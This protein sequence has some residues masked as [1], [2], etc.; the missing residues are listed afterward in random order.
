MRSVNIGLIGLGGM[1]KIHFQNSM[2]LKNAKVLAVAD[3]SKESRS[4]ARERGIKQVYDNYEKLLEDPAID[5]VIISLPNHFHAECA[6]KA[7]EHEKHIFIEKPLARDVEE[8]REIV[9]KARKNGVKT[10]VGYPLRFT[11]FADV[12]EEIDNGHLGDIVTAIATNVTGG[13][14]FPRTSTPSIPSP[15]PSWWFQR[16]LAGGGALLDLGS[17]MID[18]LLFY[19]GNKI[20]SVKTLLGHRFNLP[21]ED[22]AVCFIR[23]KQGISAIVNVGWYAQDISINIELYGTAGRASESIGSPTLLDYAKRIIK[24]QPLEGHSA[25]RKELQHFVDCLESDTP[26]SP[27][28]EEGLQ[29]LEVIS[30]AYKHASA[31]V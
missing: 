12:K 28:A 17:H 23:F 18:I 24:R 21:L 10:M 2:L 8:G 25:F 16:E 6:I 1:G 14:F 4:M 30:A 5:C 19:F 3:I 22:H 31:S 11:K 29:T 26:P 20:A 13:P 9:S 7:A 27:S 15:V